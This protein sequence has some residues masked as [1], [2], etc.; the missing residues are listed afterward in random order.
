MGRSGVPGHSSPPHPCLVTPTPVPT[1]LLNI[2]EALLFWSVYFLLDF[3]Y[4]LHPP[5]PIV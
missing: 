4:S 1:T 2:K 3:L 5:N